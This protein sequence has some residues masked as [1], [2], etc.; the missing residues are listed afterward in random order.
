MI[1]LWFLIFGLSAA[2]F[3]LT[4]FVPAQY[5]VEWWRAVRKWSLYI[6]TFAAIAFIAGL[7]FFSF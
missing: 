5:R 1:R 3:A 6:T 7:L 2:S 4:E